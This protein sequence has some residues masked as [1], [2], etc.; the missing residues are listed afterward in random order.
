MNAQQKNELMDGARTNMDIAIGMVIHEVFSGLAGGGALLNGA[1][2]LIRASG[3][4]QHADEAMARSAE[5]VGILGI[6]WP[7]IYIG[8]TAWIAA[9]KQLR[10]SLPSFIELEGLNALRRSEAGS[11][12]SEAKT[13]PGRSRW[14]ELPESQRNELAKLGVGEQLLRSLG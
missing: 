6:P 7:F 2:H 11:P 5:V 14:D 10:D 13:E 9:V 1:S 4:D 8:S 3:Y 12:Q